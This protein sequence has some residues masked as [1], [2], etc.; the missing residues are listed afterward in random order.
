M[1]IWDSLLLISRAEGAPTLIELSVTV[2]FL[3]FQSTMERLPKTSFVVV[4]IVVVLVLSSPVTS[5]RD[6][7]ERASGGQGRKFLKL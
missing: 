2:A 7:M 4:V 1:I 3:R 6:E 5:T